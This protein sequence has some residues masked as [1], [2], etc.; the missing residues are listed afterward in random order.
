[1]SFNIIDLHCDTILSCYF[2]KKNLKDREGHIN[3]EKLKQGGS[4]MQDFALFIATNGK[5]GRDGKMPWDIYKGMLACFYENMEKNSDDIKQVFNADDIEKNMKEGK[6][7]ALLSVEDSIG[8]DGKMER[9]E[10]MYRDGVRLL[11]LTWNFENSIGFPNSEDPELHK[12]GLKPFGIECIKRMNDMG[13]IV[14]VSHL[15]E[16]GF[17]D[18]AKY[19]NK[20]FVA[21]HSCAR[22][23][24][25]HQR[26][27]TDD[28]LRTLADKGGVVGIN[29][30]A[31]FLVDGATHTKIEYVV[32][33]LKYMKN[34]A[35]IDALAW[36]SDFD[37]IESTLEFKDYSGFPMI[38]DALSKEFTDDEIEKINSKNFL[39]VM[40]E[41][42]K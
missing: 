40:R 42:L 35:D 23:L 17:Y 6:L 34:V 4:M 27:L 8:I 7:S 22:A 20:P 39:R 12:K 5:T 11:T 33:H 29:F 36:G 14:D 1:M 24:C 25:S 16:G 41:T 9:L 38:L 3:I 10:E 26:D 2:G 18:V 13:M 15:S 21:S 28:Q 30:L 37:G 32:N 19:T 31:K